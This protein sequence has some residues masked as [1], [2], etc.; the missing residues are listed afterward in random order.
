MST[1]IQE[2]TSY[3]PSWI[4][5]FLIGPS[6]RLYTLRTVIVLSAIVIWYGVWLW[7][8]AG[9]PK[10]IAI[11][12]AVP[13]FTFLHHFATYVVIH[14]P[15]LTIFS[16][17][18][19]TVPLARDSFL[20]PSLAI[21]SSVHA[22]PYVSVAGGLR[23]ARHSKPCRLGAVYSMVML[24]YW[25]H[26]FDISLMWFPKRAVFGLSVFCGLTVSLL[27]LLIIKICALACSPSRT[28]WRR[29]D[30]RH[31]HGNADEPRALRQKPTSFKYAGGSLFGRKPWQEKLP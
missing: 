20:S 24:L 4:P 8:L 10:V 13:S 1:A 26:T 19:T 22:R 15:P 17:Q 9:R 28:I 3:G 6:V 31:S 27:W 2:K 23:H 16:L 12:I 25:K 30:I 18:S 7:L 14:N 29:V 5:Q 11:A 21:C